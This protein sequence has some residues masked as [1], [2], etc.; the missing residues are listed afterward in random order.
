MNA[1]MLSTAVEYYEAIGRKSI[2]EAQKYLHPNV[3]LIGPVANLNGKKAV[4]EG[5][6]RFVT[7]HNSLNIRQKFE[8]NDQ[9]MLVIYLECPEPVGEVR[10]AS[11]LTFSENLIARIELFFDVRAFEPKAKE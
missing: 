10:T 6:D 5:L 4:V 3:Q 2:E 7:T 1:S 9:V 11:M 8:N